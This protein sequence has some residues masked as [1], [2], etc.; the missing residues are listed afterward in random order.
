MHTATTT[1]D[2]TQ[3]VGTWILDPGRTSITFRTRSLWVLPVTGAAQA[4]SG[5]AVVAPDGAVKG[6]LVIDAASFD[7][8]NKKRDDH[9]R[10]GDFLDAAAHPTIAFAAT[11]ARPDRA[12]RLEVTGELTVR[13]RSQPLVVQVEISGSRTSAVVN[14]E[15]ELDRSLWGMTW[16][17][18]M[19]AGLK[20]R[21]T[22]S[23]HFDRA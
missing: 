11:S 5:A 21:I 2:L 13:G 17:A 22:V 4:L 18:R 14:S 8:K 3:F 19:G 23:A 16:G 12:G 7:T 6:G 1:T 9:L 20:N 10:S 15:V